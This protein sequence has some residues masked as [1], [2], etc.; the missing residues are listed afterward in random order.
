M[1]FV[2]QGHITDPPDEILE[3]S[4]L[5]A[6]S[7]YTRRAL[8]QEPCDWVLRQLTILNALNQQQHNEYKRTANVQHTGN[9]RP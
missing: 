5:S 7:G 1:V 9:R 8:D 2:K 6:F 3:H 4:I